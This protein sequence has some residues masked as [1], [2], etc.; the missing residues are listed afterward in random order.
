LSQIQQP[1][2]FT[3]F[4]CGKTIK[5][6]RKAD[7]SGWIRFDLD[8]AT[9]HECEKKKKQPEQSPPQTPPS[10]A[11]A[12]IQKEPPTVAI[13]DLADQVSELKS[14]IKSLVTQ[15]QLMQQELLKKK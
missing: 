1:K 7:N 13:A 11:A 10:A 3:C 2:T 4:K 8:G 6:R 9:T 14:Q 12:L 5:L 15:I